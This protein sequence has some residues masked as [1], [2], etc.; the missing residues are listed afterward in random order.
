MHSGSESQTLSDSLLCKPVSSRP[1][2]KASNLWSSTFL[3]TKYM[4]SKGQLLLGVEIGGSKLQL[5]AAESPGYLLRRQ[6]VSVRVGS[7]AAAIRKE[8]A[9]ALRSWKRMK[10][11]A[12]GVGFGGPVDQTTVRVHCSHQ[13]SGWNDVDLCGWLSALIDAPVAVDNDANLGALAESCY[14]AG[15]GYNPAFY[16][17][18]G[19]GVGGGLVVEDRIYQGAANALDARISPWPG[20]ASGRVGR[21]RGSRR[22]A[23]A[24]RV[25]GYSTDSSF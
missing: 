5:L 13:V 17:N 19:S 8:I 3:H 6:R 18:S 7:D 4:D 14:G 12:A 22:R 24:R 21:R 16:T 20:G 15:A 25:A 1:G 23:D 9:N 10:W 11:R 2:R